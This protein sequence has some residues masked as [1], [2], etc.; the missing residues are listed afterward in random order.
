[1]NHLRIYSITLITSFAFLF[2][3]NDGKQETEKTD[4]SSTANTATQS[5][6]TTAEPAQ[7]EKGVWHYTCSLGCPGGA[8]FATSCSNCKNILAHNPLYHGNTSTNQPS[9]TFSSQASAQPTSEPSQNAAGVW[10]YT[11]KNGCVGGAGTSSNCLTCGETL[12]HNSAYH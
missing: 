2:G 11:C 12:V 6:S 9:S 3:C 4:N 5:T 1:M 10:H 8:G 7:N